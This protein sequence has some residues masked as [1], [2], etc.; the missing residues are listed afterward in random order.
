VALP[1]S[2]QAVAVA[3]IERTAR[4]RPGLDVVLLFGS[5]AR[6]TAHAA[7]DWDVGYLATNGFDAAAWLAV[8]VEALGTD[9]VDLVD[10]ERASGLLRYRAARDGL[11]VYEAVPGLANRFR[12]DAVRF[13]C[14]AG[15][16]LRR[17]YDA[18]LAELPS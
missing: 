14:D 18:V 3:A 10:L 1:P 15:P 17:G 16:V 7:S 9:H 4:G 13:W 6:G 8:L 12:L 5:R 11:T 2:G